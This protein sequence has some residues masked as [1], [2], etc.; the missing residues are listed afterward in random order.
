MFASL[1]AVFVKDVGEAVKNAVTT[2]TVGAALPDPLPV[3]NGAA[4]PAGRRKREGADLWAEAEADGASALSPDALVVLA[5][6]P[7]EE[8]RAGAEAAQDA[9]SSVLAA[10]AALLSSC[11][12]KDT[13]TCEPR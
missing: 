12:S 8:R 9:G 6:P 1:T 11:K 13:Q 3:R 4:V 10:A 5:V 2:A 7:G